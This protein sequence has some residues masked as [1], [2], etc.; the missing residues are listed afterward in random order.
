M[1]KILV[2]GTTSS[3]KT[4]LL[5]A[6]AEKHISRVVILPEVA[7]TLLTEHPEFEQDPQ[8]QDILFAEQL[9]LETQAAASGAE[10]ILCDRGTLD[11]C[12][13]AKLF[14]QELKPEWI[15]WTKESYDFVFWLEKADI[16]FSLTVLQ[17]QISDRDWV[18][19]R[20]E[21]D[22]HIAQSLLDSELPWQ[23]LGGSLEQRMFILE[24]KVRRQVY[25]IEGQA[26]SRKE[27]K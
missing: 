7:R 11:I 25:S 19:F 12:A 6:L 14:A 3:G 10:V 2:T 9:R 20:D 23:K 24:Q 4:T 21:L 1:I 27:R 15:T 5:E 8:L 16:I 22:Q 13:H 26:Q 18:Q 17:Q